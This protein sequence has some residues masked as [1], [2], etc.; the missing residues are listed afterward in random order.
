MNIIGPEV[1]ILKY[2]LRITAS[3]GKDYNT[4]LYSLDAIIA[5]GYRVNSKE[6]TDFRIWATNTIACLVF[7]IIFNILG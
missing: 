6:A 7:S 4:N 3:D 5:V 2:M 1:E